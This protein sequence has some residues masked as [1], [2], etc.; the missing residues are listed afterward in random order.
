[1]EALE[2]VSIVISIIVGIIVIIW[3]G[4]SIVTSLKATQA[5]QQNQQRAANYYEQIKELLH[6]IDQRPSIME[7]KIS[8]K[9]QKP[10]DPQGNFINKATLPE[11]FKPGKKAS[12]HQA[13]ITMIE[14]MMESP[15]DKD[16]ESP[17]DKDMEYSK[18]FPQEEIDY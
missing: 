6:K 12:E 13:V 10:L 14:E 15:K 5:S 3:G 16:M 8:E 2:L 7:Q 18:T 9:F 17:K 11:N 4:V 1:M